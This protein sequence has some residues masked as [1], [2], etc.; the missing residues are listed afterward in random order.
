MQKNHRRQILFVLPLLDLYPLSRLFGFS[1]SI[2]LN[3]AKSANLCM[4]MYA[5]KSVTGVAGKLLEIMLNHSD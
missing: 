3:C 4:K 2:S 5:K 1:V